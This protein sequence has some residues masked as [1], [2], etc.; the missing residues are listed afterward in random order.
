MI[1]WLV[2][3]HPQLNDDDIQWFSELVRPWTLLQLGF[4]EKYPKGHI[5]GHS[6][7]DVLTFWNDI[8]ERGRV[9]TLLPKQSDSRVRFGVGLRLQNAP[10][11]W[12]VLEDTTSSRRPLSGL[13]KRDAHENADDQIAWSVSRLDVVHSMC[14]DIDTQQYTKYMFL[15]FDKGWFTYQ[16]SEYSQS[17]SKKGIL[18]TISRGRSADIG[19]RGIS[20]QSVL[21]SPIDQELVEDYNFDELVSQTKEELDRIKRHIQGIRHVRLSL[22]VE[23]SKYRVDFIDPASNEIIHTI[24]IVASVDL[25]RLIRWPL[26]KGRGL[27]LRSG[28]RVTWNPLSHDDIDYG[29]LTEFRPLVRT[30]KTDATTF[31]APITLEG[32][33]FKIEVIHDDLLCPVIDGSSKKHDACWRLR[34]SG[35][36]PE[37]LFPKGGIHRGFTDEEVYDILSIHG[38]IGKDLT[39]DWKF[40]HGFSYG[41]KL[42]FNTSAIMRELISEKTGISKPQPYPPKHYRAF[43]KMK[44]RVS[45]RV[46]EWKIIWETESTFKSR[47]IEGDSG[48]IDIETDI[49]L[50]DMVEKALFNIIKHVP[51][52]RLA[53]VAGVKSRLGMIL[54]SY[55]SSS[56][57]ESYDPEHIQKEVTMMETVDKAED[58]LT[59][60]PSHVFVHQHR[61]ITLALFY[62]EQGRFSEGID[63]LDRVLRYFEDTDIS[64]HTKEIKIEVLELKSRLLKEMGMRNEMRNIL[65]HILTI[66][67]SI[68]VPSPKIKIILSSAASILSSGNNIAKV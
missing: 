15:N 50:D 52:E 12:I 67:E 29:A 60:S 32:L 63:T 41:E 14:S 62:Y 56:D 18:V 3:Q 8:V 17:W 51:D 28:D 40:V 36:W 19:L 65:Q 22:G 64:F 24:T 9:R 68:P 59:Q 25:V 6:E 26:E 47:D 35:V 66:G 42:V 30:S 5:T 58:A 45:L 20:F 7:Y 16:W 38:T 55:Y 48:E 46:E 34:Y 37:N 27:N 2:M 53:D 23:G 31:T 11:D 54:G 13:F 21:G 1:L 43:R 44:W 61:F 49:S 33:S 39:P 57:G 10:Y 4:T